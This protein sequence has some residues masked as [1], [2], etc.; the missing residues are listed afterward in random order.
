[1]HKTESSDGLHVAIIMDGN[2]RWATRRGLPRIAG[3][4][5][6]VGAVRR[7]VEHAPEL[8]IRALTLYAFSSDNWKRPASEVESIFWLMRAYLRLETERLRRNNVQ[9]LVIGRRDRVPELLLRE[10]VRAEAATAAGQRLRLRVAVDYSSRDAIT[11]AAATLREEVFRY[12]PFSL[13]VL[14]TKLAQSL[15]QDTGEV[16]L[17]IRTGG[18]KRL[19]D[20]LLWESAYA[21]LLFTDR[22]W[23]DFNAGDLAAAVQEFRHRERRFGAVSPERLITGFPKAQLVGWQQ[24]PEY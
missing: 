21:E 19:S 14:R 4:R 8:G 15:A 3:H 6:G 10:I 22:M 23:P 5:A 13:S 9:L 20:F 2:G 1:M 18:E 17:L 11:S 7:V 24:E 16:D 12:V